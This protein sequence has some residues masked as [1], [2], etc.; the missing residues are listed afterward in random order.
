MLDCNSTDQGFDSGIWTGW[1][2]VFKFFHVNTSACLDFLCAHHALRSLCLLK[3]PS[4][5]FSEMSNWPVTCKCIHRQHIKVAIKM[6]PGSWDRL[7][8]KKHQT[9]HQKV[10]NSSP[11][12]SG[13]K[14]FLLQSNFLYWLIR[15]LSHPMLPQWHVKDPSHSAKSAGGRLHL[16]MHTLLTHWSRSGLTMPLS[17]Q[18]VGIYQKTSTHATYQGTLG[19]SS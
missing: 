4:Q 14:S 1:R 3:I 19:Q 17:G 8:V 16:N 9:H 6:I 10:A 12:R 2:A 11:G 15:C 13:W 18:N 5:P 7:L